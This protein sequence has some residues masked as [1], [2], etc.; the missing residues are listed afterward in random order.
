MG[1]VTAAAQSIVMTT[2]TLLALFPFGLGIAATNQVAS[3]IGAGE[4]EHARFTSRL[5]SGVAVV[6]GC[7]SMAVL[8]LLRKNIAELF[9]VGPLKD[10]LGPNSL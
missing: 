7:I 1:H 2:D 4:I 10:F 8:L 6:N 5:A 3:L 9:T